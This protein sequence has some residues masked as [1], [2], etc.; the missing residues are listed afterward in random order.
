MPSAKLRFLNSDRS[1]IGFFSVSSQIRKATKPIAVTIASTTIWVE[2]NQSAS[3]P[4][5]SITCSA[6]TQTISS[7]SPTVSMGS[8]RVGRL[9]VLQIAPSTGHVTIR[10]TGTLIRKIQPQ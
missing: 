7:P 1:T 3:L 10:P 9:A 4:V 2:A 6:P 8:L 5:S